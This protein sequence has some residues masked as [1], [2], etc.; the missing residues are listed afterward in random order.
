[1]RVKAISDTY[2]H[3]RRCF[4]SFFCHLAYLVQFKARNCKMRQNA[5]TS[6]Q[7]IFIVFFSLKL[8]IQMGFFNPKAHVQ[9]QVFFSLFE[10]CIQSNFRQSGRRVLPPS[11]GLLFRSFALSE[12]NARPPLC[13]VKL[14]QG[15]LIKC[16]VSDFQGEAKEGRS[17][18]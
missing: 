2:R 9:S 5:C 14:I 4:T 1:M 12:F 10:L 15:G 17:V 6:G 7:H 8:Y 13:I 18:K 16:F 3:I 11:W